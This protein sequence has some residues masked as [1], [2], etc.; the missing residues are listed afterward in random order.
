MERE[1]W[2]TLYLLAVKLDNPWGRRRYSTA[3][4]LGV[5]FLAS[6]PESVGE[7]WLG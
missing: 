3:E 2:R 6:S 4:V 1:L 5:Y 7:L